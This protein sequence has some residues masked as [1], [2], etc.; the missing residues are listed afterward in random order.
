MDLQK[1][2]YFISEADI[3]PVKRVKNNLIPIDEKEFLTVSELVRGRAKLQ[4]VNKV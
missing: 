3:K 2:N 4:D 1:I